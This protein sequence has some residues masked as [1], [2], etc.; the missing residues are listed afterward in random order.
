VTGG[1][2]R[3]VAGNIGNAVSFGGINGAVDFPADKGPVSG[4]GSFTVSAW[5]RAM[6]TNLQILVQQRDATTTNG[7]YVL[8]MN[9][10]GEVSYWEGGGTTI[11]PTS[12]VLVADEAWHYVASV[13]NGTNCYLY[14][15]GLPAGSDRASAAVNIDP[16]RDLAFAYDRRNTNSF[17]KGSL[18]EVQISGV[19][20]S[21]SWIWSSYLNQ[22]AGA[23]FISYGPAT[24]GSFLDTNG[25][26]MDD[27]WEIHY[28]G[29]L[30]APRGGP[31]EDFDGDG[32]RN[33]DEYYAGTDPT[34]PASYIGITDIQTHGTNFIKLVLEGD[35]PDTWYT[36][37][38]LLPDSWVLKWSSESN[39]S[40]IVLSGT[41][42]NE[43]FTPLTGTL[44]G[45]PP[46]NRYTNFMDGSNRRF[47]RIGVSI[48]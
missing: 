21:A 9:G 30:N 28:F 40:Y 8:Q 7:Q 3:G 26:G 24:S 13:R 17:F 42:I 25:N 31:L 19:A 18:D 23:S 34:N 47:Y 4:T 14:V 6:G 20:R 29:S 35:F 15:D 37:F 33:L 32:S 36:Q 46:E 22:V 44:P 1:A 5:V 48:P 41:N 39:K 43:L 27:N 10:V 16:L 45:T 11:N 38:L 2:I 12:C